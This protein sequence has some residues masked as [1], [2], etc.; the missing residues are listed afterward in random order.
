MA[1]DVDSIKAAYAAGIP[2]RDRLTG[3]SPVDM[4]EILDRIH[5]MCK[6]YQKMEAG[7]EYYPNATMRLT[8]GGENN[9]ETPAIDFILQTAA[10]KAEGLVG[11]ILV[12]GCLS[13]RYQQ[14]VLEQLPEVDG[15]LGT[16]S[17]TEIV[18]AIEALLQGDTVS[19]FASIDTPE[20]ETG[21]I[22]TTPEHYAYIKIA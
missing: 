11:K 16:G 20:V 10:L 4:K 19:D 9:K 1:I 6:G 18:P 22:L 3:Y 7:E 5:Q 14:E 21:R 13:Q 2:T 17:Y 15:L 12:T 8:Y